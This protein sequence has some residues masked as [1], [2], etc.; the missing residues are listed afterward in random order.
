MG[1][2]LST[3]R[4]AHQ[5]IQTTHMKIAQFYP[6]AT[7]LALSLLTIAARNAKQMSISKDQSQQVTGEVKRFLEMCLAP[8]TVN[9]RFAPPGLA[10]AHWQYG[11]TSLRAYTRE[12]PLPRRAGA[13]CLAVSLS[14]DSSGLKD[15][16][17]R[18]FPT[19][20]L[21]GNCLGLSVPLVLGF[22]DSQEPRER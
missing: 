3:V 22:G 12:R 11:P 18:S 9:L 14:Y 1:L 19:G 10:H 16:K 21:W 17:P 20:I 2:K 7:D 5:A 13:L 6:P 15:W 4:W 8:P